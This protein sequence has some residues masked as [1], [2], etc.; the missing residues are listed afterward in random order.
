MQEI[1]TLTCSPLLRVSK[2]S[3]LS[4]QAT[5]RGGMAGTYYSL[6]EVF[7]AAACLSSTTST[8]VDDTND[9]AVPTQ[10]NQSLSSFFSLGFYTFMLA[11]TFLS[12]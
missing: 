10:T 6:E 9:P 1:G 4:R 7:T 2:E 12:P 5:V 8:D 11:F 3:L